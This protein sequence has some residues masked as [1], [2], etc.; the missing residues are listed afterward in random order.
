[1]SRLLYIVTALLLALP[2]NAEVFYLQPGEVVPA[3]P[4]RAVEARA[5]LSKARQ[6]RLASWTLS[7]G[8]DSLILLLDARNMV[9]GISEPVAIVR[10][11][12]LEAKAEG[13]NFH[14]GANSVAVEWSGSGAKI[15][16]GDDTLLPVMEIASLEPPSEG[17]PLTVSASAGKLTVRDLIVETGA[18][19]LSA[20]MTDY[21][22]DELELW[23]YLDSTESKSALMGGNYLFGLQDV[24]GG[25]DLIYLSGARVNSSAWRPGM[26]KAT[27]RSR[28]FQNH[29]SL[30]WVDSTGREL[31]GEHYA[32]LD[33][34]EGVLTLTFPAFPLTLRL[35]R[36]D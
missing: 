13:L 29:Y 12:G 7:W 8:S 16:A 2:L 4:I 1:M 26:R 23:E 33:P 15:L 11:K 34:A 24:D 35:A 18:K 10:C 22:S 25:Y 28:G 21:D 14:G 17:Q 19:D 30:T 27:L 32:I 6:G 9:D 31:P 3:A 5:S 36:K 20:L